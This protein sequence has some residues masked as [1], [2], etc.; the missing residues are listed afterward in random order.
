VS[1]QK[2]NRFIQNTGVKS[3]FIVRVVQK[4]YAVFQKFMKLSHS[5]ADITNSKECSGVNKIYSSTYRRLNIIPDALM[6]T[7][8]NT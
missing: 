5:T 3:L 7:T 8:V 1:I 4:I 6:Y 2:A